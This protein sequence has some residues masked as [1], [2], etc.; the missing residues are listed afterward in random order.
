[1]GSVDGGGGEV[2]TRVRGPLGKRLWASLLLLPPS[3]RS[4]SAALGSS[5]AAAAGG[6]VSSDSGALMHVLHRRRWRPWSAT[7]GGGLMTQFYNG[8]F[9]LFPP[10]SIIVLLTYPTEHLP[11]PAA[12]AHHVPRAH[13]HAPALDAPGAHEAHAG[14]AVAPRVARL[15]HAVRQARAQRQRLV[16]AP[17]RLPH[18]LPAVLEQVG[19]ELPARQ[20]E[21]VQAVEVELPRELGD[22]A[23]VPCSDAFLSG[24]CLSLLSLPCP[25]TWERRWGGGKEG[26]LYSRVAAQR[27]REAIHVGVGPVR[28]RTP[29]N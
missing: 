20:R 9:S 10:R 6:A 13:A 12:L 4:S 11:A 3:G 24:L 7:F 25:V 5:S 21:V 23:A 8:R 18:Q 26:C 19:A 1:M 14:A 29:V 22:D 27:R 2:R 28:P 15:A 16:G 17:Q